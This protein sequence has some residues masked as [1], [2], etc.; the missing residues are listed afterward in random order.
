MVH[1]PKDTVAEL[2]CGAGGMGLGFSQKF[3]I[4][5]AVDKDPAVVRTYQANNPY[6]QVRLQDVRNLTGAHKDFDGI[7]GIIGGPP[8]QCW[9]RLNHNKKEDDPRAGLMAE[10]MRLVEEISPRFFVIENVPYTPK[11]VKEDVVAAGKRLGFNTVP[12][13]VDAA[14]YGSY[15]SRKRWIVVGTRG[16]WGGLVQRPAK[17]VRSALAGVG[18]NWGVMESS[19]KTLELL[20]TAKPNEWIAISPGGWKNATKLVWDE[21]SPA[22]VNLKKVYMV[23]PSLNRNISLAEAAALQGFPATYTWHGTET[24][25]AQMIANAMPA[26]LAAAVAESI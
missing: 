26:E 14:E 11:P 7:T 25:I 18:A 15:Q 24:E 16:S 12:L 9:S 13:Y 19:E 23:H 17:T 4:T 22:I 3:S 8:C 20:K 5:Y 21:P 10:F 6:T 2:F 1:V